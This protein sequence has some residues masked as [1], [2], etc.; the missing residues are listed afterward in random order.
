MTELF[1]AMEQWTCFKIRIY[2]L[3]VVLS[4][5]LLAIEWYPQRRQQKTSIPVVGRRCAN[6]YVA[7]RN[8]L[9]RVS[10]WKQV[11]T[12]QLFI[13]G[14]NNS[15][16]IVD[17][18]LWKQRDDL[19]PK[20]ETDVPTTVTTAPLDPLPV[21]D[22]RHDHVHALA[23]KVI[24]V[25]ALHLAAH[26]AVLALPQSPRLHIV[27]RRM[28][29]DAHIRNCLDRHARDV[30][31]TTFLKCATDEGVH[32]DARDVRD[33]A[34]RYGFAQE[35]QDVAATGSAQRTSGVVW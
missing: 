23:Q 26:T 19:W 3:E 17:L 34:E 28:R 25:L 24:H 21:L 11:S 30:K 20:S 29:G 35:T 5:N 8:Q 1:I 2:T 33:V 18:H 27:F 7:T 16:I 13:S 31:M 32:S 6:C 10:K 4:I 15:R 12:T 22:P 9:W 14:T